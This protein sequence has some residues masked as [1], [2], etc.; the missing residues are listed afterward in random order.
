MPKEINPLLA[1]Q[2]RGGKTLFKRIGKKGMAQRGRAGA[3]A[4]WKNHIKATPQCPKCVPSVK[5][6]NAQ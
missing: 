4:R 2:T 6:E 1:A 3:A 5:S